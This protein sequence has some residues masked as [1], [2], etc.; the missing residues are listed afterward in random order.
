MGGGQN[1]ETLYNKQ[2]ASKKAL[3]TPRCQRT[4]LCG[5]LRNLEQSYLEQSY[6]GRL[7]CCAISKLTS[8]HPRRAWCPSVSPTVW[9]KFLQGCT[10]E[11]MKVGGSHRAVE[12]V[13]DLGWKAYAL[14]PALLLV[15]WV[16]QENYFIFL[17]LSNSIGR[18]KKNS[19]HNG[20]R[21]CS[22]VAEHLPA[23]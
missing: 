17:S 3:P 6:L 20:G 10:S 19:N 2:H 18:W 21:G 13:R 12:R 7:W 4:D 11:E 23:V 8:L 1:S 14:T 5:Q 9:E 22:S 15:I 16:I